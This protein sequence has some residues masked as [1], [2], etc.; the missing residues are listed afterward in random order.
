[1]ANELKMIYLFREAHNTKICSR[2]KQFLMLSHEDGWSYYSIFLNETSILKRATIKL[3][4]YKA[5]IIKRHLSN[6]I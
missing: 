1:M 6:V 2:N 4:L 5:F 3:R